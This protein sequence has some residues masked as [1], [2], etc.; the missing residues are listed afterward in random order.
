M[1]ETP[2]IAHLLH[3]A[4]LRPRIAESRNRSI[5]ATNTTPDDHHP[6]TAAPVNTAFTKPR[7]GERLTASPPIPV[8]VTHPPR[9]RTS[10]STQARSR[11]W[12]GTAIES[13]RPPARSRWPCSN[14]RR[15]RRPL[16]NHRVQWETSPLDNGGNRGYQ[17]DG[18]GRGQGHPVRERH[19]VQEGRPS[20][21]HDRRRRP[22]D[23]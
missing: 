3:C 6:P 12:L 21:T 14:E 4:R 17:G 23:S 10:K 5:G 1:T 18:R 8:P 19:Q 13:P 2:Q 9:Y 15:T 16:R 20:C 22:K 11:S 7:N